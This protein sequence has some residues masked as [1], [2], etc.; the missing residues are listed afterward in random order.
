MGVGYIRIANRAPQKQI[1]V[2]ISET[3][4][5][6]SETERYWWKYY[7]VPSLIADMKSFVYLLESI[8]NMAHFN[9]VYVC[10]SPSPIRLR[11][12]SQD[13]STPAGSERNEH[14]HC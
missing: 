7:F 8:V 3:E 1:R 12:H 10:F 6:N 9:N 4:W 14:Q 11:E 13:G 5:I 2:G